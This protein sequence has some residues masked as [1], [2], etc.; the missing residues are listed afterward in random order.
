M[1]QQVVSSLPDAQKIK[2]IGFA[3]PD[4]KDNI[5]EWEDWRLAMENT[6]TFINCFLRKFSNRET[7]SDFNIRKQVTYVPAHAK[8]GI[9]TVKNSIFQRMVDVTR[10]G[11][12]D[13]YNRAVIGE[14]NGV[15]LKGSTMNA[16]IGGDI[17]PELLPYGKVGIY[18]DN[19]TKDTETM[20]TS[21]SNRPYLYS[22]A[23][24]DIINW[25]YDNE[26]N[27]IKVLLRDHF[28][29]ENKLGLPD[30]RDVKF[31]LLEKTNEGVSVKFLNDKAEE[32]DS[33]IIKLSQIPFV[34]TELSD[35]LM[36]DIFKYQVALLNAASSDMSYI[37]KSNFPFYVEQ[38]DPRLVTF[39]KGPSSEDNKGQAADTQSQKENVTVSTRSG[40]RYAKGLDQPDFI[41]PS[42]E[43]LEASMNKQVQLK[44]EIRQLLELSLSNIHVKSASAESKKEDKEGLQAGLSGIGLALQTAETKI[45]NIWAEYEAAEKNVV[46]SYPNSYSLKTDEQRINEAEKL[47]KLNDSATSITY[48]KELS[49]K[50]IKILFEGKVKNEIIDR[51]LTEI[52]S[53]DSAISN[54]DNVIEAQKQGLVSDETAS[55]ILGFPKGEVEQARKDHAKR[56]ALIQAAQTSD[57]NAARGVNDLS[58][59]PQA[60]ENEKELSNG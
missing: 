4:Y 32:Q 27:L 35:G 24:E 12:T 54:I 53:S 52:D 59:N 25:D 15:D 3:H 13:S 50:I 38:Y 2:T 47:S 49:K 22:Y 8:G 18:I 40:R 11:G 48:K 46:V 41:H 31:R 60:A 26:N 9:N 21:S 37:L 42:S 7:D 20:A 45:G 55:E 36:R 58:T 57:N 28:F 56:V 14:D 16:Y 51:M 29:S 5:S 19:G 10:E 17:L 6:E 44:E 34:I 23:I 1:V 33:T 39:T 30:T 43:P